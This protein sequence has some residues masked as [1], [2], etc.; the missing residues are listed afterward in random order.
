V[1]P[2]AELSQATKRYGRTV[3]LDA[4]DLAIPGGQ[5]LALLGPNGAGKTTAISLMLGLRRPTAGQARLFGLDPRDRRARSRCGAML[6]DTQLPAQLRVRELI[7]LFRS[8]YPSPLPTADVL[9][10]AGLTERAGAL[11]GGL[12]GGQK[13]RLQFGLAV[14][15]GPDLL[16][17]DEPTVGMDVEARRAFWER[18]RS[19]AAAGR[20]ILLTTHYLEEADALA[21]RIVLIQR[22]RIVADAPPAAIKARVGDKRVSFVAEPLGPEAF[23]DLPVQELRLA[24]GRVRFTSPEPERVL[25]ELFARGAVLRDLEVVGVAL[26]DA[27]LALAAGP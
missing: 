12:S 21:E 9:E 17:L 7:D 23:A 10:I 26:E 8:Y 4:V 3:A 18:M 13:Q 1:G 25:R 6:Q 2:A 15:G 11:V 27:I 19:F 22:G 24:D 16:F 14:C 5:I 20:T